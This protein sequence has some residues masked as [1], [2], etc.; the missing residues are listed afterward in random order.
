MIPR[1]EK[2]FISGNWEGAASASL[3]GSGESGFQD[4][5]SCSHKTSK[6]GLSFILF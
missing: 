2:A 6:S 3:E 5:K 1:Q 4:S